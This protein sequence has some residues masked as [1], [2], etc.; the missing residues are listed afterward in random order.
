MKV[1]QK[2]TQELATMAAPYNPRRISPHDLE[3]LG[4]SLR[5]FG[6]VEPV[7]VNRRS[8]HIVGGHQRVKAAVAEGMESLPVVYVDLDEPSEKQLNLALNRITGEFE[9][10][11]LAEVLADLKRLGADLELTG[12]S[13]DELSDLLEILEEPGGGLTDADQIPE[14]V[15]PRT[16]LGDLWLLGE[17]RL[18]CGDCTHE[19]DVRLVMGSERAILFA[20]DPPYLVDY[21]GMNHPHKWNDAEAAKKRKNKDWS[22]AYGVTWDESPKGIALYEDAY[23]LAIQ[24]AVRDNAAW[25]C[26][27]ASKRQAVLEA[28]WEKLGGFVHQQIIWVKD[29]P[30]LTRST[31]LW[32]HEPCFHGWFK[33][34]RP[35]LKKGLSLPSVW[36]VPTVKPGTKTDHPTS[37]PVELFRLPMRMHTRRGD[38]CYEPFCGSGSQIIAAEELGRRCFALEIYPRFCDVTVK[39]WE[40]FSGKEAKHIPGGKGG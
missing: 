40:E 19:S 36:Q 29:R 4:R 32:Q 28:I 12:F 7:V 33:G 27:H 13:E 34:N 17:H 23:R 26:W 21:D 11:A 39:R 20:T 24:H 14:D 15:E 1:V 9:P 35:P 5:F 18:L 16:K 10:Q 38:V 30:V 25:Y 22:D 3:S 2:R 6:A 31:Y 8:G 37:K